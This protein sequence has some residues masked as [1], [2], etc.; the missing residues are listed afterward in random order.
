MM[1]QLRSAI[2]STA[3]KAREIIS[4]DI[5][6]YE[7]KAPGYKGRMIYFGA[8]KTHVSVFVVPRKV[9]PAL[10]KQLKTYKVAKSTLRFP[11]GTK[12]PLAMIKQLVKIRMKEINASL[13]LTAKK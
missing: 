9:P 10:A 3:P 6:F 4:Y 5:P 12:I 1:K 2:K 13:K 8:F 7:Y 11:V